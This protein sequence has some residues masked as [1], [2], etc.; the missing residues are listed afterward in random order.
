VP[1]GAKHLGATAGEFGGGAFGIFQLPSTAGPGAPPL[2]MVDWVAASIP[3]DPDGHAWSMGDDPHTLTVYVS[4]N[5]QRQYAVFQDDW[6]HNGTRTWLAVVDMDGVLS[7][8]LCSSSA[9]PCRSGN[10]I[11]G[12]LPWCPGPGFTGNCLV[13]FVHN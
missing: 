5:N 3:T 9:P 2:A 8:P 6:Q 12:D 11:V 10:S 7:M 1:G 13:S 4:P